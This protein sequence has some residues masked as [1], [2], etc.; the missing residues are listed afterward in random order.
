M[1]N[2]L[3]MGK[4]SRTKGRGFELEVR[5]ALRDAGLP[6]E[7]RT[8]AE[9]ADDRP[10]LQVATL[11]AVECK[12]RATQCSLSYLQDA[13][14]RLKAEA[15]AQEYHII[16]ARLDRRDPVVVLDLDDFIRLFTAAWA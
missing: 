16:A 1:P 4:K 2:S 9:T 6:A 15:P 8:Q 5:K 11:L 3:R 10:D 14:Q 7:R 12:R 13:L